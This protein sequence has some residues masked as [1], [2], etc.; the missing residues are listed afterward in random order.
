MSGRLVS[1]ASAAVPLIGRKLDEAGIVADPEIAV[2]L[3]L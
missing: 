2:P 3:F 1:K